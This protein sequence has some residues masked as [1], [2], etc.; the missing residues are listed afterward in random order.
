MDRCEHENILSVIAVSPGE[1]FFIVTELQKTDLLTFLKS[2][3]RVELNYL[4]LYC[5][6]IASVSQIEYY[7]FINI[8]LGYGLFSS[9]KEYFTQ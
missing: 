9:K 6:Q 8:F 2:Q 1:Q 5:A 7:I 4:Y 3:A